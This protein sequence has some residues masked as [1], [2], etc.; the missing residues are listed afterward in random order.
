[1]PSASCM[2]FFGIRFCGATKSVCICVYL[3]FHLAL[4]RCRANRRRQ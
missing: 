3:W 1:V 4:H 2:V